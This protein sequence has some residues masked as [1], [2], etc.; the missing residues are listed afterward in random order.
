EDR[1][2]HLVKFVKLKKR[3]KDLIPWDMKMDAMRRWGG[4]DKIVH[5][6]ERT[7]SEYFK[8]KGTKFENTLKGIA[9]YEDEDFR[10]RV[11]RQGELLLNLES[12]GKTA[13]WGQYLRSPDVY[14]EILD[15]CSD[16]FLPLKEVAEIKYGVKAGINEFFFLTDDKIVHW[17]IEDEFTVPLIKSTKDIETL[18]VDPAN[19]KIK[20]FKCSKDKKTLLRERKI[21]ALNYIKWG[22]KQVTKERGKYKKGGIPFTE[23]PSVQGRKNWYDIGD[24]EPADFLINQFINARFFFP[25]NKGCLADHTVFEGQIKLR[26]EKSIYEAILNST[27]T[28]LGIE[29]SGRLN[30]GEG[31]LTFYGP[32]IEDLLVPLAQNISKTKKEEILKAFDKLLTRPIKPI[33]EEVKMKDRQRLDSLV[34]SAIGLDPKKYLKPLYEGLC[35]LV[36]ERIELAGMRK[37]VK[38]AKTEK[39]IER[40]MEQVISEI[41]P[42][43][44]RKFPEEFIDSRYLKPALSEVEGEAKEISISNEPL[45]LGNYFMGQQEVVSDSGFKYTAQGIEEAKFIIYSQKPN[46][47]IVKLPK[48]RIRL[49]KAVYEYERYIKGLKDELFQAFFTRT[50]DHKLADTLVERVIEGM[51]II[52]LL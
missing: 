5:K 46:C 48:D 28:F 29:L 25:V 9:T 19:L 2:N 26:K 52:T 17:Q 18:Q 45:K 24:R 34:L 32:D 49:T 40:L 35:D 33:F 31:L 51:G 36:R 22:E 23:V 50:H 42:N 27:I 6:I 3:L 1:D 15:K 8:L 7:G 44:P 10:I 47:Y 38:N 37:K 30:L 4:L 39:D 16:K 13:K 41:I 11:V 21:G 43:G 14:F 12:S 20:V